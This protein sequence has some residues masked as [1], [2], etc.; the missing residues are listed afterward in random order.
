MDQGEVVVT[1]LAIEEPTTHSPK[2]VGV[3]HSNNR[4]LPVWIRFTLSHT[5]MIGHLPE[6]GGL[7]VN[8]PLRQVEDTLPK[9]TLGLE[10]LVEGDPIVGIGIRG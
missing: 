3:K 8:V 10:G 4:I 9:G 7:D 6:P 2:V 5:V 1:F